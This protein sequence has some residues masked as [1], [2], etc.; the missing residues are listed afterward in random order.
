MRKLFLVSL[1]LLSPIVCRAY[2]VD[3]NVTGG[4]SAADNIIVGTIT[5]NTVTS[6]SITATNLTVTNSIT[7]GA[8]VNFLNYRKPSLLW[9][10][11]STV[12]LQSNVGIS[13]TTKI[14]FPDG[15]ARTVTENVYG[16]VSRFRNFDISQTAVFK[17]GCAAN[18]ERT[19]LTTGVTQ[20]TSNWFTLYAVKSQCTGG[21]GNYV[22]VGSTWDF[23]DSEYTL[24]NST[25][26]TNGYVYLGKIR[27]G[28]NTTLAPNGIVQFEMNGAHTHFSGMATYGSGGQAA[29]AFGVILSSTTS[30]PRWKYAVGLGTA[31]VPDT[32]SQ[33]WYQAICTTCD[34]FNG[35]P[36][37]DSNDQTPDWWGN[38]PGAAAFQAIVQGPFDPKLGIQVQTTSETGGQIIT[39]Y[40]YID[41]AWSPTP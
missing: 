8:A 38:V 37:H 41:G 18:A 1:F 35:Q 31:S 22:V 23:V 29:K 34:Q 40:G 9:I 24:L 19:G 10:S 27:N 5:A 33:V 11:A 39:L 4:V 15:N 3:L 17:N 30:D 7:L 36:F 21:S 16:A 14:V 2:S 13:S 32:I 6:S 12:T 20:G 26:G 28:N 25:F